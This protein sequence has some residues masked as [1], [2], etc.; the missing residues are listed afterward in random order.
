[1]LHSVLVG[2]SSGTAEDTSAV[3]SE[4]A[5]LCD[6]SLTAIYVEDA[7]LLEAVVLPSPAPFPPD[8]VIPLSPQVSQ[9]LQSR[10]QSE[11]W[12][13][14]QRFLRMLSDTRLAGRFRTERGEVTETLLRCSRSADLIVVGTADE[15]RDPSA[16]GPT[17]L[18]AHVEPLIRK[19][20]APVC[21]VPPGAQLGDSVVIAY[22]GGTEAQRALR[23]GCRLAQKLGA[24]LRVLIAG[25][26]EETTHWR[27]WAETFLEDH[28]VS[29]EVVHRPGP[30]P[31]AILD[32][33]DHHRSSV[34]V[35]GAFGH[36][37]VS[38]LLGGAATHTVLSHL[39]NVAVVY[40]PHA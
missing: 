40:G 8:G 3:A 29:A 15:S 18:G 30:A 9:E 2:V 36:G 7:T 34:L 31:R 37:R 25:D 6:A 38:A 11:E 39:E 33:L 26:S 1:M 10:F 13:L 24:R 32:E 23:G 35:M 28:E 12:I 22:D 27:R 5:V 14:G 20:Y 17:G 21:L 4:L 19:A 16:P